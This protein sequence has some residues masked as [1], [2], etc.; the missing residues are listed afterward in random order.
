MPGND[1]G[2]LDFVLFGDVLGQNARAPEIER[3]ARVIDLYVFHDVY[4]C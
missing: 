1:G 4:S 3:A 2:F